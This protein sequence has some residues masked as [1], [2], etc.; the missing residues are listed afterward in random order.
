MTEES[1]LFNKTRELCQTILDQPEVKSIHE[2]INAFL[3]DDAARAQCESLVNKGQELRDKQQ[4]SLPL[5]GEEIASFEQDRDALLK[6]SVARGFIDAQEE[7]HEMKHAI[8]KHLSK[9][10][11]L[12]RL[13]TSEDL[14]EGGC[15]SSGGGGCGCSH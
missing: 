2:R 3:G 4:N 5:S 15:C 8:Q 6:N 11:E 13:P 14:E 10:L 7:L 1:P 9:T 12:G